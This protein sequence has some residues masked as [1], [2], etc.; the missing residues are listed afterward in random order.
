MVGS[1]FRQVEKRA[2]SSPVFRGSESQIGAS[3]TLI[4]HNDPVSCQ[5]CEMDTN[6]R[7]YA[8]RI[9]LVTLL[10]SV[11]YAV[12]RYHIAGPV[13]WK[14]FPFFI[15]NKGICLAAFILLTLNFSLGPARNLGVNLSSGWLAARKAMGMTGF[16]L[17]LIHALM[18]F[19][20]FTPAAYAKFFQDNGTLTL[21]AG[22]SMLFG[23][24]GFVVLWGYNMSFQTF[25]REDQAFIAFI[26]SRRFMLFALLLGA[27]HLFFM[28]YE[29]WLRPAGW[30]GGLPPISLVAFSFFAVGYL[31]NLLGRE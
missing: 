8:G 3:A 18:S 11:G 16:L 23:V 6:D 19:L 20:L 21:L 30:H 1:Q 2:R 27:A 26:T 7:N 29:G 22:L 28:G 15:L 31:V 5:D 4:C 12:L 14:D 24:L 17:V 13:P 9:I 25:L 10:L